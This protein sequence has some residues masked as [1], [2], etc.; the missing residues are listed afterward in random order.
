MK[1]I[2][3]P[4]RLNRTVPES[5]HRWILE[6]INSLSQK[7]PKSIQKRAEECAILAGKAEIEKKPASAVTKLIWFLQ[8]NGWTVYD[9]YAS[10]SFGIKSG[11]S[12]DRM[13][14]FYEELHRRD[15]TDS[16]K[17]INKIIKCKDFKNI[18]KI[19]Y[20][21]GEFVI[22][23]FCQLFGN[24]DYNKE[25]QILRDSDHPI[26]KLAREIADKHSDCLLRP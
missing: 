4:Y 18:P 10:A 11:R 5:I 25:I 26:K 2:M 6:E 8:R 22:D 20:L 21:Y 16:A 13:R 12:I 7:W 14:R 3:I 24:K 19:D 1:E 17:G 15:F 9:S 23:K